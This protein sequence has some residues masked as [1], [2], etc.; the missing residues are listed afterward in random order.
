MRR[1]KGREWYQAEDNCGSRENGLDSRILFVGE[2]ASFA[3]F[4]VEIQ[5][6]SSLPYVKKRSI[7]R[8]RSRKLSSRA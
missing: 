1:G 8:I 7:S 6:A 4:R 5:Q 2:A 3:T